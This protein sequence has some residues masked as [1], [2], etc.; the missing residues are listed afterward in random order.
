MASGLIIAKF[1]PA[2][3]VPPSANPATLDERN[4]HLVLDFDA[5]ATPEKAVFTGYVPTTYSAGGIIGALGFTSVSITGDFDWE[6]ELERVGSVLDIDADSFGTAVAVNGTSAT[7]TS[8][9]V[10]AITFTFT[11]AAQ[12]DG[13]AAGEMFRARVSRRGD[14]DTATGDGEFHYLI[15]REL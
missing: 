12:L 2:M 1:F 7:A 15:L 11:S 10:M 6:V 4:R 13:L 8:G 5:G 3:N 9:K 14:T